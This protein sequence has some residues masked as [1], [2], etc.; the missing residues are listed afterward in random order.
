MLL[1]GV[2][3]GGLCAIIGEEG[4]LPSVGNDDATKPTPG[5]LIKSSAA[6]SSSGT[7]VASSV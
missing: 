1:E 7:L 5:E 6:P 2:S 3:T 4:W